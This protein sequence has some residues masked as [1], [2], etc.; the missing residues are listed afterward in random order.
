MLVHHSEVKPHGECPYRPNL[1][2][3]THTL[4]VDEMTVQECRE[5]LE[6]GYRRSGRILYQPRCHG[7]EE[8]R[9][10]RV[11]V[12]RFVPDRSQRRCLRR[13]QDLRISRGVP[14]Y[15]RERLDLHNRYVR[16]RHPG[17][18]SG[19]MSALEYLFFVVDSPVP[20]LEFHYRYPDGSLAAQALVDDLGDVWSCV[21]T[22]FDPEQPRRGLGTYS[23]LHTL[24][25]AR[26]NQVRWVHLGYHVQSCRAMR[27]KLRFRP[28]EVLQDGVWTPAATREA[29]DHADP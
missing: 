15:S 21:F 20:T 25:E 17:D 6:H 23:I 22:A 12:E 27:Y 24:Q 3:T 9:S 14:R 4:W 18:P 28:V 7:C 10:T 19:E 8:C 26:A 2:W 1:T 16:A 5:L 13:N 11:D 29:L